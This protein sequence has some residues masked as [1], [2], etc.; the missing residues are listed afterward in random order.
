MNMYKD[1]KKSKINSQIYNYPS[2]IVRPCPQQVSNPTLHQSIARE[3][4]QI[5]KV[6]MLREE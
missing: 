5:N 4:N 1:Q 2:L 3:L 6:N